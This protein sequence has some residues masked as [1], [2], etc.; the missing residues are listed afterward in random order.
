MLTNKKTF[1]LN[2]A[3]LAVAV[4]QH[5][6]GALPEVDPHTFAIALSVGN[7]ALRLLRLKCGW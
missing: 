3:A 4:L 6:A 7:L 2:G 1:L 5:Y